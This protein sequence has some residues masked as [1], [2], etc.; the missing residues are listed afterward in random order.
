[1][2]FKN[3]INK[4]K[5][6]RLNENKLKNIKNVL[7]MNREFKLLKANPEQVKTRIAIF[8]EEYNRQKKIIKEK[9][10][11]AK[12]D[13]L[14]KIEEY[15]KDLDDIKNKL[16]Y[17]VNEMNENPESKMPLGLK[18]KLLNIRI[19]RFMLLLK[20]LNKLNHKYRKEN[21]DIDN[22]EV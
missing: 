5:Q 15:E 21:C 9:I 1:M 10:K 6:L 4:L 14:S 13:K 18:D 22:F 3:K 11:I 17:F 20:E 16:D 19:G 12:F 8:Y 2:K 7:Q